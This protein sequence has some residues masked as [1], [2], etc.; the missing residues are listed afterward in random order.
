MT[1]FVSQPVLV[2]EVSLFRS[3]WPPMLLLGDRSVCSGSSAVAWRCCVQ[4]IAYVKKIL[5]S[6]QVL[7][8]L[9][10]STLVHWPVEE[11]LHATE[12][13]DVLCS[14]CYFL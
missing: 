3:A 7:R 9:F 10:Y 5:A 4:G 2:P 14:D 12:F 11:L 6:R 13:C 1:P 8:C